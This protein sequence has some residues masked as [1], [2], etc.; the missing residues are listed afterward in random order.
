VT[1][2]LLVFLGEEAPEQLLGERVALGDAG[3]RVGLGERRHLVEPLP[4]DAG[5]DLPGGHV[6]HEVEHVVVA[7]EVRRLQRRRLHPL[8]ER[9][10]VLER[11]AQ[12]VAGARHRAG[13]ARAGEVRI[14]S[15]V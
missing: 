12:E 14:A 15:A 6:L 4:E 3:G 9:V 8:A 5:A 2:E 13:P 11:D 10:A 1:R 7:E